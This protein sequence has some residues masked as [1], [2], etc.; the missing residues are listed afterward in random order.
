MC[1][2]VWQVEMVETRKQVGGDAYVQDELETLQRV[3]T[4]WFSAIGGFE[5]ESRVAPS[6]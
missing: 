3:Y 6:P 1:E 5:G 2:C 4:G